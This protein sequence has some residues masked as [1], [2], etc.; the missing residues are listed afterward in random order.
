MQDTAGGARGKLISD[1]LLSTP[2][3]R[4]ASFG[5]PTRTYLHQLSVDTGYTLEDL[6]GAMDDRDRLIDR[7][8]E[9]FTVSVTWWWWYICI[10]VYTIIVVHIYVY[11]YKIMIYI[12]IYIYIIII[13]I[14]IKREREILWLLYIYR[15]KLSYVYTYI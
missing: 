2:S 9:I 1:I 14:Y 15:L 8:R 13:H 12:Y 5:R 4:H 7:V 3:H 10:Y 6:P 11:I